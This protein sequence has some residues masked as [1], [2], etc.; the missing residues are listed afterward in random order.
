MSYNQED[1]DPDLAEAVRLSL[2]EAARSANATLARQQQTTPSNLMAPPPQP[3]TAH[4]PIKVEVID[5][6]DDPEPEVKVEKMEYREPRNNSDMSLEEDEH[7][8]Y[9]RAISAA[10]QEIRSQDSALERNH[11]AATADTSNHDL[12]EGDDMDDD[13]D[14][15]LRM[16]LAL[17]IASSNPSS[18]ESSQPRHPPQPISAPPQVTVVEN[19]VSFPTSIFGISRAEMERERQERIKKRALSDGSFVRQDISEIREQKRQIVDHPASPSYNANSTRKFESFATL[20]SS[21][22][23]PASSSSKLASSSTSA[24]PRPASRPASSKPASSSSSTPLS[25]SRPQSAHSTPRGY[26][27]SPSLS[28][29][30]TSS[31]SSNTLPSS[32]TY[33]AKYPTATFRNTHIRGTVPGKWHVRLEDLVSKDH[34]MKAVVTTMDINEEWL[35][36][37]LP[38]H[39]AQ[40]RV[41]YQK[42]T[43]TDGRA[44]YST[45]DKIQYVHP[46]IEGFGSFHAKLMILFYPLFCRVVVSSANLV[47]HDW[48]YLVNTL[49]VQ[50][51][52]HLP[53]VDSDEQLGDF[54]E[55]LIDYLTKMQIP[56]KVIRTVV[57]IPAVNGWHQVEQR[58]TY[59]IARLA[60]VMQTVTTESQEWEVEYQTSSLG[61]LS[62]KFLGEMNRAFRG[63]TPRP[64][65]KVDVEESV[66]PI[67]VVFPTRDHVQ[68]SELGEPGAGT[69]C[70]KH[71][72]WNQR[73]FPRIVMHDFELVGRQKGYLMHTKIILAQAKKAP[74]TVGRRP[75]PSNVPRKLAG[76][77]YVGSANC[78]ESAWGTL[79]NKRT[80][81]LQ[82]LCVS[83]RNWELG[84][85]Y[86]IETEEELEEFNHRYRG[87]RRGA[88]DEA[89]QTFFGPLPV[90]YQR[91][92][93]PYYAEDDAWLDQI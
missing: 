19:A 45:Q 56:N 3:T 7:L 68:N 8:R 25:P 34:L 88:D 42:D 59:G 18:Q 92:L 60:K 15:D 35:D 93:K 10:S 58:H 30:S 47:D 85:V 70:L 31:G 33:P 82:G 41:I 80:G 23:K 63:F 5:L 26:P 21:A 77:F 65:I 53:S 78:T 49:Y 64:R 2:L 9:V 90:P 20:Q 67:K 22:P 57:L 75:P 71:E 43:P 37:Y 39:I 46:R 61:R 52:E 84:V 12:K 27:A 6:T 16:A 17:S 86:M 51:F 38:R 66:P 62:V 73:T 36:N 83:I 24:S 4:P 69:V 81:N 79:M 74:Q 55:T 54:G 48:Q 29:T 28:S 89:D 40:C 76:W 13:M 87:S 44:R 50:D 14:D 1:D 32:T 91:P 11:S 72:F